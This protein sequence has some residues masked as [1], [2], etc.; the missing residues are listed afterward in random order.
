MTRPQ[1]PHPAR[2]IGRRRRCPA[3]IRY[4]TKALALAALHGHVGDS[5][6][7]AVPC[8]LGCGGWHHQRR[9]SA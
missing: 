5:G 4:R 8:G 3:G 9:S 6:Q 7:E 2:T 1:L